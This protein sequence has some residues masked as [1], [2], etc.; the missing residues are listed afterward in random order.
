MSAPGYVIPSGIPR[1]AHIRFLGGSGL[2]AGAGPDGCDGL[3]YG[4]TYHREEAHLYQKA[5]GA[6]Y[7]CLDGVTPRDLLRTNSLHSTFA[8]GG[9]MVPH[10]LRDAESVAPV[11]GYWTAAGFQVPAGLAPLIDGLR[12]AVDYVGPIALEHARLA[13]DVL[14]LNYHVSMDELGMMGALTNAAVWR[15]I[16]A[17]V[18]I[19]PGASHG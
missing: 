4:R 8:V 10:I 19:P 3:A 11:I 13:A 2:V 5:A 9:W 17:A 14:A 15:I 18:G 12:A 16:E 1:P 7:V 6:W